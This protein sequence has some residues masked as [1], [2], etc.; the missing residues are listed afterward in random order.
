MPKPKPL[1]DRSTRGGLKNQMSTMNNK[2]HISLSGYFASKPLYLDEP[3]QKNPN[4]RKLVEQ[5]CQQTRAELWEEVT[6]THCNLDFIQ[7]KSA[8]KITYGIVNDICETL[9][10]IP[11]NA[12]K[13]AHEKARMARMDKYANDLISCAK[14][15]I[16]RHEL[17]VPGTFAPWTVKP[18]TTEIERIKIN[19]S[20]AD[21]LSDFLNFLGQEANNL[22]LYA[23][24]FSNFTIQ[25]AWN[26]AK[27][28]PVGSAAEKKVFNACKPLC[29]R[30][31]SNR[32]NWNPFPQKIKILKGHNCFIS[33]VATTPDFSK[34]ISGDIDGICILWDLLSGRIIQ[35]LKGHNSSISCIAITPDGKRAVSGSQD[36][37]CIIW[38]LNSGKAFQTLLGHHSSISSVAIFPDGERAISASEDKTCI[39]WDINTART[40]HILKGHDSII[41]SVAITP[42]GERA[43][44]GSQDKTC[45]IWDLK[46]GKAIKTLRG[47]NESVFSVSISPDGTWA[48]SVSEGKILIIWDINAGKA[49]KKITLNDLYIPPGH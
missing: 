9:E 43:I 24:E 38:D 25:Q 14:G 3:T 5:P 23:D 15:K 8:A 13:I 41:T 30:L 20:R 1:G 10:V 21:R 44:S 36:K 11:D 27:G 26:Y 32:P 28:G 37:T 49:V 2:F 16:S 34:A 4:I 47:H 7:A 29:L 22:Q 42:D 39:L 35:L 12:A 6:Q 48:S 18:I 17:E 45:I 46:V 31:P 19:Q 40:I 33:V